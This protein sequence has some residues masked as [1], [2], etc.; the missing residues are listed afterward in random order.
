MAE[1]EM[2]RSRA[3]IAAGE[4]AAAVQCRNTQRI[5]GFSRRPIQKLR[6]RGSDA[7][8]SADR[9]RPPAARKQFWRI[10]AEA[11]PNNRFVAGNDRRDK[12]APIAAIFFRDC[13]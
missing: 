7:K 11:D 4:H 5:G 9:A 13:E 2:P 3:F 8:S 1:C 6:A 12:T 10:D